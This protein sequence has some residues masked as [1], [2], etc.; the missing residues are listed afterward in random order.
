MKLQ[1]PAGVKEPAVATKLNSVT[2]LNLASNELTDFM[3][4]LVANKYAGGIVTTDA[5]PMFSLNGRFWPA[6]DYDAPDAEDLIDY[7]EALEM[8]PENENLY[9]YTH[10]FTRDDGILEMVLFRIRIIHEAKD[11]AVTLRITQRY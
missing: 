7:L 11:L 2:S 9:D 8:E 3:D 6:A 10:G 5:S 4:F 1:R